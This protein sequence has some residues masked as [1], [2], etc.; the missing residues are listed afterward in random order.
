MPAV[1]IVQLA[2]GCL[3]LA[4]RKRAKYSQSNT[5]SITEL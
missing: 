3:A 5:K 4:K 2:G 1:L